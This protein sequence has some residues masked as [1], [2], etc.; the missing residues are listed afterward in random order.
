MAEDGRQEG[1]GAACL[2]SLPRAETGLRKAAVMATM[3]RKVA[4]MDEASGRDARFTA[5]D[6][7]GF[8]ADGTVEDLTWYL[9]TCNPRCEVRAQ[10]GL[11]AS[12]IVS[13]RPM[14]EVVRHARRERPEIKQ[15]VAMLPRYLFVGL[16]DGQCVAQ[17]RACDGVS[18]LVTFSLD[19]GPEQ[20][21]ASEVR[22]VRRYELSGSA[23]RQDAKPITVAIGD[24]VRVIV[25]PFAGF[26]GEVTAY[27]AK[28]GSVSLTLPLLGGDVPAK[29]LLDSVRR[30]K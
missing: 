19:A 2:P 3:A 14:R 27:S 15:E 29:L 30:R 28:R 7:E 6:R 9:A 16:A 20:V 21:A 17:V 25:G 23:N 22:R 5:M 18:G 8:D 1:D 26:D 24:T 4:V 13:Y 10:A 11:D 12:G